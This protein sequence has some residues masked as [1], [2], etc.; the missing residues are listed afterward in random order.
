MSNSSKF[1]PTEEQLK[2]VNL[3]K[4]QHLVLAP[5]GTGKTE[6]LAQRLSNAVKKGIDQK[7]MICLTFTNRAAKNMNDRVNNEIGE[8][9]IFIGN[10][11]SYCQSFLRKN[12]LIPDST[13]LMDDEDVKLLFVELLKKESINT[14]DFKEHIKLLKF[15]TYL[16][17]EKLNFPKSLMNCP[18]PKYELYSEL[19]T[20]NPSKKEIE[21]INIL[22]ALGLKSIEDIKTKLKENFQKIIEVC[23]NYEQIKKETNLIDFDDLLTLTYNYFLKKVVN[24]NDKPIYE[25]LQIDEVQDLNPLQWAIVNKIS[26]RQKSH[27]VFFGDYEQAIFS[28]MGA[29]IEIL[30]KVREESIVHELQR[31][32]RSPQYLLD[33]YNKYAIALLNPKWQN[34]P[35]SINNFKREQNSLSFREI[36]IP[37]KFQ[38]KRGW[39]NFEE[40]VYSSNPNEE[41]DWI[42]EKKLPKEPKD[43]TA[44]LVHLNRSADLIAHKFDTKGMKYFKISG[45]DL[46]SRKVIK[47]LMAFLKIIIDNID[48]NSWIRNFHLYGKIKTLKDSRVF[49]NQLFNHG[50]RPLDFIEKTDYQESYLD[51]F[52]DYFNNKRIIVFDTE[53]TGLDTENDDI[54]QIAAIEIIKGKIGKSFEVFINTSKDLSASEKIHKISKSYLNDNAIDKMVALQSFIDFIGDDILIAHNLRYDLEILNSNLSRQGLQSLSSKIKLYDSIE[55]AKRLYTNLPSYKLEYLLNELNIEGKNSHNALDDVKATVN[56]ITHTIKKIDESK[57]A[58]ANFIADHKTILNNFKQNF[59][60]LYEALSNDFSK[61]LPISEVVSMIISYMQDH[62]NYIIKPNIYNE[63]DKLTKHMNSKC[64]LDEVLI[65]INKYIPEY[66]KYKESDLVLGNEKIMI[67]TIHKAKGLEFENV[68][69][70]ACTDDNYPS[71][72]AK[73]EG[74]EAIIEN[75]RLLYVAM[76]R[77]KK[78]LLITSSTSN[79]KGYSTRPSRF[80][81]PI[82]PML[83][84]NP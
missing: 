40:I 14:E 59:S 16:K 25:W 53:T 45:F 4:N 74:E 82:M 6:L 17:Q 15:N 63:I 39:G 3:D 66:V 71:Y 7:T 26:N 70:P 19:I 37:H 57:L 51:D 38:K 55:I 48:R 30:D 69:I 80:L 75:A 29:K 56:L 46:F 23:N 78:R 84:G 34:K 36:K 76:T 72:F 10:I 9:D 20:L 64:I 81:N 52:L 61:E 2:V 27:R 60:P 12:N 5:P 73:K 62:M 8:H 67:S 50:F 54:I 22:K 42:I 1:T 13:S 28:F 31:N 35:K 41:I 47:D 24:V 83:L 18:D 33:L 68:I 79:E 58:R 21:S 65:S 32:F 11:H 49:I 43:S 44:I 77:A